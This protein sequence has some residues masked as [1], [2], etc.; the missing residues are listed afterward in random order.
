MYSNTY[1]EREHSPEFGYLFL[2]EVLDSSNLF[3]GESALH[4]GIS[5]VTVIP[6]L[7]CAMKGFKLKLGC[8]L[9]EQD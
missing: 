2:A 7:N 1:E 9:I 3:F 4:R 5:S 6:L 8:G